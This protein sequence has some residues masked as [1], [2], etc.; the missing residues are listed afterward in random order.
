MLGGDTY[1]GEFRDEDHVPKGPFDFDAVNAQYK[2]DV[3]ST[4]GTAWQVLDDSDRT[5]TKRG[6]LRQNTYRKGHVPYYNQIPHTY[7]L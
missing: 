1:T 4:T 3:W 5:T 6:G 7:S 2:N